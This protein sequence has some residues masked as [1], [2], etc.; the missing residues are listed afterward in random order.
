MHHRGNARERVLEQGG[1]TEV[2]HQEPHPRRYRLA[3]TGREVVEHGHLVAGVREL[4]H[5]VAADVA[6][7][8]RD[9]DLHRRPM[10]WYSKPSRFISAGS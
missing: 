4:A 3:T 9:Q 2:A 10:P 8:A 5:G 1:V 6:G 7:A